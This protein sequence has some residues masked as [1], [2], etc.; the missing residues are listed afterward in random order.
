MLYSVSLPDEL[1]SSNSNCLGVYECELLSV[2]VLISA[3]MISLLEGHVRPKDELILCKP[4]AK[5]VRSTRCSFHGPR[6]YSRP[7]KVGVG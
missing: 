3:M 4:T 7:A 2:D 6:D 5:A 1:P